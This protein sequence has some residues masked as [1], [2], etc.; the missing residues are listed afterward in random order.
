LEPTHFFLSFPLGSAHAHAIPYSSVTDIAPSHGHWP[1]PSPTVPPLGRPPSCVIELTPTPSSSVSRFKEEWP[2][3]CVKLRSARFPSSPPVHA[4]SSP[5]PV[6]VCPR[7]QSESASSYRRFTE[8][9]SPPLSLSAALLTHIF[10]I[11]R[12]LTPPQLPSSCRDPHRSPMTIRRRQLPSCQA[13]NLSPRRRACLMSLWPNLLAWRLC[14]SPLV[15]YRKTSSPS[16]HWQTAAGRATTWA[17][18][19]VTTHRLARAAHAIFSHGPCPCR[20]ASEPIW[21]IRYSFL[22]LFFQLFSYLNF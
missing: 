5:S 6:T 22:F 4:A 8:T 13:K 2:S 19:E 20:K 9:P 10:P 15:L 18:H 7:R 12:H 21:P 3:L 1:A 16:I 11:D 14:A 17:V